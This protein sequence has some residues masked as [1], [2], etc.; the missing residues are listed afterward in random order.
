M[1]AEQRRGITDPEAQRRCRRPTES[2]KRLRDVDPS[3]KE[4]G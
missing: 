2:A 3:S 1:E 4:G